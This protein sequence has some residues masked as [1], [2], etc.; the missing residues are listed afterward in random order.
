MLEYFNP[1]DN[2]LEDYNHHKQIRVK[3]TRPPNTPDQCEFKIEGIT[4][5]IEGKDNKKAPSEEGITAEI[6][7]KT[8]KILQKA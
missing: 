8:F 5:V 2:E 7:K 4:R 1:E 3:T 6:F